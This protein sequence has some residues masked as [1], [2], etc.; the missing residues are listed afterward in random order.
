MVHVM[1]DY[2]SDFEIRHPKDEFDD[3][4]AEIRD[5][6]WVVTKNPNEN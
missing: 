6:R 3:T 4:A 5:L 1:L 2:G